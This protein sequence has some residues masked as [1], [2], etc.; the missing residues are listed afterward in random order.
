M[1]NRTRRTRKSILE[2]NRIEFEMQL[3]DAKHLAKRLVEV[4][5]WI[6]RIVETSTPDSGIGL[7][8]GAMEDMRQLLAGLAA[9]AAYVR[10]RQDAANLRGLL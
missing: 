9:T 5:S 8:V 4:S 7:P 1:G 10:G 6:E 3:R 2:R